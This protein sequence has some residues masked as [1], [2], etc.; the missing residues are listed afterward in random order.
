MSR[1]SRKRKPESE[2]QAA[3]DGEQDNFFPDE[4]K[5]E[6]ETMWEVIEIY[7]CW[8]GFR[9]RLYEKYISHGALS[10]TANFPLSPSDEGIP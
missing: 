1:R 9:M 7:V 5:N 3:A 6:M 2:D 4:K 10:D 8:M